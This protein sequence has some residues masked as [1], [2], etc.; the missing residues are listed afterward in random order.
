MLVEF[1]SGQ[2]ICQAVKKSRAQDSNCS[3]VV[4]C[5]LYHLGCVWQIK[6]DAVLQHLERQTY[7]T[8]LEVELLAFL[9]QHCDNSHRQV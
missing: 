5:P 8:D 4:V 9:E 3:N 6:A 7:L 1:E 2:E